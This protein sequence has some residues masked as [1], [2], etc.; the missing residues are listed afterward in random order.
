MSDYISQTIT[1]SGCQLDISNQWRIGKPCMT[2][3]AEKSNPP[4]AGWNRGARRG[5]GG[6]DQQK[7]AP[8]VA[9]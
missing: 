9:P 7:G 5:G 2:G 8:F 3:V 4:L 1:V 6:M